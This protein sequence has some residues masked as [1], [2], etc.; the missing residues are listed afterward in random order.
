[1]GDWERGVPVD[2]RMSIKKEE[3]VGFESLEKATFSLHEITIML[4]SFSARNDLY[5]HFSIIFLHSKI[6]SYKIH[7]QVP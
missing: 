4:V 5:I 1:V 2:G 3:D 7:A 6:P